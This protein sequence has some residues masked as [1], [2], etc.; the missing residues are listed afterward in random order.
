MII[1]HRAKSWRLFYSSLL[2]TGVCFMLVGFISKETDPLI[3][4]FVFLAG[5]IL[6]II[7]GRL[8][9]RYEVDKRKYTGGKVDRKADYM[10]TLTTNETTVIVNDFAQ[11]RQALLNLDE[12]KSG[13]VK[14]EISPALGDIYM[15]E[16]LYQNNYFY[17][18]AWQHRDNGNGYWYMVCDKAIG[19]E[20]TFKR[21][22]KHHKKID[23]SSF[24]KDVM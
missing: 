10:F 8:L 18:Y 16:C 21:L 11:I 12:T 23:F 19:A 6:A 5:L 14:M 17:T 2:I 3:A 9:I 24:N 4:I 1:F 13:V 22:Y 20:Y 7:G 15:I